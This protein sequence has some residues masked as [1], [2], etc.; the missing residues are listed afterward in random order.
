MIT[1]DIDTIVHAICEIDFNAD[2]RRKCMDCEL[3]YRRYSRDAKHY[4]LELLI[5]SLDVCR[6]SLELSEND[7]DAIREII[8][9]AGSIKASKV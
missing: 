2:M 9:K 5:A 4:C 8:C 1:R 3:D 7:Y 6:E